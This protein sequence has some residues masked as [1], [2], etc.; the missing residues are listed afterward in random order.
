MHIDPSGVFCH[1]PTHSAALHCA[2]P[3]PPAALRN[4]LESSVGA[5]L[6]GGVMIRERLVDWSQSGPG[7]GPEGLPSTPPNTIQCNLVLQGDAICNAS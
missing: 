6:H 3:D 7:G 5:L 1:A 4:K 2:V